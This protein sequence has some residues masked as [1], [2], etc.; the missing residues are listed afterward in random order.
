MH[1]QHWPD[2]SVGFGIPETI[3]R[4]VVADT[5]VFITNYERALVYHDGR[6]AY[7]IPRTNYLFYNDLEQWSLMG[8]RIY[9]GQYYDADGTQAVAE[10]LRRSG[11]H[12][13][14]QKHRKA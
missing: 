9:E 3:P 10:R 5:V 2:G 8:Q 13:W 1:Q 4:P 12:T 14:W 11:S 7:D 6:F